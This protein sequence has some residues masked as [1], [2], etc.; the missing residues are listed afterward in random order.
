MLPQGH[1]WQGFGF[2]TN[3]RILWCLFWCWLCWKL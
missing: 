3:I 1:S 2:P